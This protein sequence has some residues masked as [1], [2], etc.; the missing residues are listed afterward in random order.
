[1][2]VVATPAGPSFVCEEFADAVSLADNL[3]GDL[4][5]NTVVTDESGEVVYQT[6]N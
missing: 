4:G 3:H 5:K 1:M 2:Y 6:G